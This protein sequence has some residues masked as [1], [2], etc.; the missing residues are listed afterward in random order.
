MEESELEN[1]LMMKHYDFLEKIP[2]FREGKFHVQDISSMQV[3]LWAAPK[4]H[5]FVVD[6]C[7]AP[8]GKSMHA[9]ELMHGTG[10]VEARD[11]SVRKVSLIQENID[12]CQLPNI[13]AVQAD[14]RILDQ[15][16]VGQ[17]DLVI[18]D[19]PCS[20]LGVLGKKADIKYKVTREACRT[21]AALQREILDT[22]CQYVK[23]D[24]ILIYST[25][26]INPGENQE[27]TAWFLQEHPEF[28]LEKQQQI[29]PRKGICDGFFLAKF[30]R[31]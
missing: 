15:K 11:L 31:N 19:L 3:G 22:V 4:E 5:S 14:A 29:L 2:A 18:A 12:R 13:R 6:V 7:A 28:S 9:A 30:V 20:G 1:V 26:T 8:G 24:G 25:C 10:M 23:Q 16:L 27:N 17:A 21:L